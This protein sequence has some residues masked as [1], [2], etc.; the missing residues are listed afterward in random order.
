MSSA[1][2]MLN[3]DL[4]PILKERFEYDAEVGCL[5]WQA[6]RRKS[7]IGIRPGTV[8]DP[9]RQFISLKVGDRHVWFYEHQAIWAMIYGYWPTE[10]DHINGNGLDNRLKNLREV[11][12]QENGK[13]T[14]RRKNNSSGVTGVYWC[15][16]TCKWVARIGV[17]SR[18]ICLGSYDSFDDA[19]VVRK[20]AEA[21]FNFHPNHG[22]VVEEVEHGCL[23]IK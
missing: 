15:S 20:W 16:E 21:E 9:G 10:I 17:D 14:K 2:K 18:T 6:V 7:L 12:H 3:E 11:T 13:N 22:R 19:V 8:I 5:R 4:I 23:K 1:S